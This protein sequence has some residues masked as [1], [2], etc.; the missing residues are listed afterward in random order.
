M[1]DLISKDKNADYLMFMLHSS[2]FMPGGSPT[3]QTEE[4]VDR[5]YDT[6]KTIFEQ[7]S[8]HFRGSSFNEYYRK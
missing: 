5:L 3:F 6:L 4:A 8:L 2:E 7:I 1:V